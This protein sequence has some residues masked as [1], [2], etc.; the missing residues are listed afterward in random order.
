MPRWVASEYRSHSIPP[1][2]EMSTAWRVLKAES[3]CMAL[4]RLR[5]VG[6]PTLL[7]WTEIGPQKSY[8]EEKW[9][10]LMKE[11]ATLKL[12]RQLAMTSDFQSICS[13]RVNCSSVN[14]DHIAF[15][16]TKRLRLKLNPGALWCHN[17]DTI[18]RHAV[19]GGSRLILTTWGSLTCPQCTGVLV[20]C[21]HRNAAAVG[22]I[23]S[24]A[25]GL[26]SRT[27]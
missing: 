13:D 25:V 21:P 3:L 9:T 22:E 14:M 8:K 5:G 18:T 24:R 15:W 4:Y 10:K 12:L 19:V 6:R 16:R 27:P 2:T 1:C 20:F 26:I 23:W 17:D 7:Y 11:D